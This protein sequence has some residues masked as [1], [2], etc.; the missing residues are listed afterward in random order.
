MN[1]N[2]FIT[3]LSCALKSTSW[4]DQDATLF[5]PIADVS[6]TT[7]RLIDYKTAHFNGKMLQ[8]SNPDAPPLKIPLNGEGWHAISIGL[9]E[10]SV[11]ASAIEVRLS[12]MDYWQPLFAVDGP[13]HEEPWI[14]ADITDC[15]LQVRYPQ[16]D[17]WGVLPVE[18]ND[19]EHFCAKICSVRCTPMKKKHVKMLLKEQKKEP[20]PML[21]TNDGCG[22]FFFAQKAGEHIVQ[23]ALLP[24][25]N[26]DFSICCFSPGGADVVNYPSRNGKLYG[27]G[28]WDFSRK[29]ALNLKKML[30]DT[31]AM[32][33]DPLLQANELAHRNGQEA[34]NYIRPQLWSCDP[35][36]DHTFRSE[37]FTQN[38]EL[39][40]IEADGTPDSK[41]SIAFPAVRA[42]INQTIVECLERDADG[43]CL[44]LVRGYPMVRYEQP[45]RDRYIDRY[46]LDPINLPDSD[47]TLQLIWA[48]FMNEW[49]ME[50]KELLNQAG[51]SSFANKRKL[52]IICGCD[53]AWNAKFGFDIRHWSHK[54]LIDAVIPYPKGNP[55]DSLGNIAVAEFA[56]ILNGTKTLL[57]P[58]LGSCFD[59]KM[60][61][62]AI[63]KRAQ[64]W[65]SEGAQGLSRWDAN[66][67]L[68]QLNLN[69]PIQ[70][71][72][73][74]DHYLSEQEI[75][76]TEI[77]GI[78]LRYFGPRLAT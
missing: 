16:G 1:K 29:M 76:I 55:D 62:A 30:E 41:M 38:P 34:W 37:F 2:I 10:R 47:P 6:P 69:R 61:L 42:K 64:R 72:L 67:Y 57:L 25:K 24:F 56:K 65:Y 32:G 70:Q 23:E 54:G 43:I 35:G 19:L 73:W 14:F 9:S 71:A 58:G 7:W 39:R 59:H 28:G 8:T 74:C 60:T 50:I 77:A 46:G 13:M 49:L 63:R 75:E 27:Q 18:S 20:F 4:T 15:H 26:S 11:G 68:A 48:E 3:D 36:S 17:G 31:L 21:Y 5:S 45:V 33:I 51:S 52:S 66:A 40:C 44:A 53:T 22:I 12:N 78:T